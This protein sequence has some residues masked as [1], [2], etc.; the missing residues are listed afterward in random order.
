MN[1]EKYKEEIEAQV[2][3]EY[4]DQNPDEDC[5]VLGEDL[6]VNQVVCLLFL[7]IKRLEGTPMQISD[8]QPKEPSRI[9]S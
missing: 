7:R 4:K 3:N 6:D 9:I 2:M 1:S 5:V 8:L